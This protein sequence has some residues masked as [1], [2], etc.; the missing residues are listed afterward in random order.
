MLASA[1]R[2]A[3]MTSAAGQDVDLATR[4]V[5]TDHLKALGREIPG[6]VS[7]RATRFDTRYLNVKG[8]VQPEAV[9]MGLQRLGRGTLLL[10]GPPGTGKTQLAAEIAD[11]LG[12]E[13]IYKTASDINTMWFGESQRN[14][15]KMFT[16][17]DPK[18]EVLFLDEA[19][20]L[21]EARGAAGNRANVAVTAEFL[22]RIEAFDGVSVCATN[23]PQKLNSALMRRFAFRMGFE[24]L[25]MIQR[26]QMLCESATGWTPESG[27]P[28]PELPAPALA[29]LARLDQLTPGDFANV[30][31]RLRARL[32]ADARSVGG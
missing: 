1:A 32:V 31:K 20:T 6:S 14:V 5:L 25:N 9:M 30:V 15:A 24:P 29:R 4:H 22:R 23:H 3:R 26:E 10:S 27:L 19:D 2:F 8:Q 28:P 13:L 7:V 12:R 18:S 17:C 16:E 21:L 11:R